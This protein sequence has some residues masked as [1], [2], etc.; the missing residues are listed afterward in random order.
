MSSPIHDEAKV[1]LSQNPKAAAQAL[2]SRERAPNSACRIVPATQRGSPLIL[3]RNLAKKVSSSLWEAEIQI[4][5]PYSNWALT[6]ESY[7]ESAAGVIDPPPRVI[8]SV[9]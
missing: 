6:L 7:T 3:Q 4:G 8:A 5:A 1:T 2:T 9:V